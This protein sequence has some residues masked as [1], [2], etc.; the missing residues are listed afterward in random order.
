LSRGAVR[1]TIGLAA[2]CSCVV[3]WLFA[4]CRLRLLY[5]AFCAG[6]TGSRRVTGGHRSV[7]ILIWIGQITL[8]A[9]FLVAGFSK[10]FA[11]KRLI[12]TLEVRRKTAPIT[13]PIGQGRFVGVLEILGAIGV[14]MPAAFTPAVLVP[15]YLLIRLAA[16]FLAILMIAASIYH[17]RRRESASPA[18][19]AL[20]LALF[21]I[22]GR[23]PH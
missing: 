2:H 4:V 15:N 17:F 18:I 3:E 5:A 12:K 16:A 20:L 10:I 1:N 13:M 7:N 11:Y 21:V 23:W 19:A 22:V 9:V 8:A 6:T 14:I